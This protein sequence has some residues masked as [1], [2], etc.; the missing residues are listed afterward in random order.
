MVRLKDIAERAGVSI[1]TV[2]KALRGAPDIAAATKA[3]IRDLAQQMG[4]VPNSLAQGLRTHS[5]R[6]I[7]LIIPAVTN[8]I[9]ARLILAIEE[10]TRALGCDLILAHTLNVVERETTAIRR[11]FSRRVEG[12]LLFPVH[13]L[14]G[15]TAVYNEL[16]ATGIPTVIL[17]PAPAFAPQFVSVQTDDEAGSYQLTQHL[18]ELGHRRIAFLAGPPAAKWAQERFQG[19]R[20]ALRDRGIPIDDHLVFNAGGTVEEG[21]K[22]A[23]QL[24]QES[25]G[26]TA[27]QA[28]NDLVAIG[29][30]NRFLNEGIRI[31]E[32]LSVTG[33]GNVL[34]SAYFRVPLT[35]ARQPKHRMGLVAM[36]LLEQIKRGQHPESPR[37][38]ADL[39]VRASTAAPPPVSPLSAPKPPPQITIH[40]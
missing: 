40:P 38:P 20:Q 26:A 25:S 9:F 32:D 4:Y 14:G 15:D 31:P 29:A 13:R 10:R 6:L 12:L 39:L 24:L 2:S 37:L 27:V 19:Y 21:D 16:A 36:D 34:T 11:M 18:L 30:A 17:G 23:L 8:P 7:G 33:F 35:T 1:M 3:R 28:V 5:T 22:A